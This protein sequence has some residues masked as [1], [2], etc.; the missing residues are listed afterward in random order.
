MKKVED[1][2][3]NTIICPCCRTTFLSRHYTRYYRCNKCK[4]V[5]TRLSMAN[6]IE[7][8]KDARKPKKKTAKD[9]DLIPIPK[10]MIPGCPGQYPGI[11]I[12]RNYQLPKLDSEDLCE[13]YERIMLV[14]PGAAI[15]KGDMI[16]KKDLSMCS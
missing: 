14:H 2:H 4:L 12:Y 16:R 1:K 5:Y 8:K 13:T 6:Y 3:K 10:H 11:K 15:E 9:L 7:N